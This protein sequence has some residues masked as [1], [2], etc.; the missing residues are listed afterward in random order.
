MDKEILKR[1]LLGEFTWKRL[2]RSLIFIYVFFALYVF[3]IADRMIF[4]PSPSSYPDTPDILKL[5]TADDIQI[6]A[7]YL[8][9]PAATYTILYIHGNAEDLGDIQPLLHHLHSLGFSVFA[10]DYRGYGTSQV[11]PSERNAYHDSDTAFTGQAMVQAPSRFIRGMKP[12]DASSTATLV[13]SA[14]QLVL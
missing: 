10:Y 2:V 12:S 14:N 11:S 8:P 6:S 1:R 13:A 7:V 4:L 3:F 9:N 5:T